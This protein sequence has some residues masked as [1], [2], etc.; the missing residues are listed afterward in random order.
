MKNYIITTDSGSDLPKEYIERYNIYIVPMHVTMGEDTLDDGSF[1]VNKVFDYYDEH[2]VLPKTS[3]STPQDNSQVFQK[4]FED[5]PDAYIIHIAY[6]GV[7]TV[8]FNAAHIAAEDFDHIHLVDSKH[9]TFG[10]TA[11][12]LATA[13]FIEE[14][15]KSLPEEIV[16]FVEDI[17]ERT[18]MVFL[19]KTLTY[20]RAG[21]RVSNLAFYGASLLSLYPT[22]VLENGYLV[23]GKKYRGTFER[24][25]KKMVEDSVHKYDLI[26]ET[27]L[28]GG[29]PDV[30]GRHKKLVYDLL[31][32]HGIEAPKWIETGAVISSHG[33]PGAIGLT[34]IEKV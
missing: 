5:H 20:L 29:A 7:T 1:D 21:G 27:V 32:E 33:G 26:P 34:G 25:L 30:D 22:I 11:V 6:S 16:A 18:Q 28:V 2:G 14:N 9:V 4:V 10:L 3:G 23:S 24:S 15:P 19:P 8:S 13:K 12:V 31:N 17:R